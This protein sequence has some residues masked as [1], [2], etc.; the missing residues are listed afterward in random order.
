MESIESIENKIKDMGYLI[1]R[2]IKVISN[3]IELDDGS[4]LE[5]LV[6]IDS[7]IR[8]RN[9]PSGYFIDTSN[10]T[11]VYTPADKR[12]PTK[13]ENYTSADLMSYQLKWH[14]ILVSSL[15]K[16]LKLSYIIAI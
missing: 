15:Q 2:P 7:V 6:I 1:V 10:A 3:Y 11:K 8:D 12:D 4:I 13:F 9:N 14:N 5:T 16:K